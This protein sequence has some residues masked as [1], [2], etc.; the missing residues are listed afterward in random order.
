MRCW[1]CTVRVRMR[2][3]KLNTVCVETIQAYSPLSKR[4][5]KRIHALK[6]HLSIAIYIPALEIHCL[7]QRL[8]SKHF[9]CIR[10]GLLLLLKQAEEKKGFWAANSLFKHD[11]SLSYTQQLRCTVS[12]S[13]YALRVQQYTPFLLGLQAKHILVYTVFLHSLHTKAYKVSG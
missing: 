6:P 9:L 3:R 8:V 10:Y 2:P 4:E 13:P 11:V 1:R 5:R 7:L 12:N